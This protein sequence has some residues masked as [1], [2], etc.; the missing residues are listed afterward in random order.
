[1]IQLVTE[2]NTS[3]VNVST[4][5]PLSFY[6]GQAEKARESILGL[7]PSIEWKS[8]SLKG[9]KIRNNI[10]NAVIFPQGASAIYS[11][12]INNKGKYMYPHL[13]NEGTLIGL[14]D[15]GFRTTDF[16]VV[17]I[18]EDGSFVP[19]LSLS[20]TIDNL[21]V[22]KLHH[23]IKMHFKNITEGADLTEYHLSR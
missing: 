10:N 16:I 22:H 21:G 2:G 6:A 12:L 8:G 9:K 5:L 4:G 17:E 19:R 20:S 7:Q 11:A 3:Q 14:I 15:I 13:M 18:Q 23:E 1:A